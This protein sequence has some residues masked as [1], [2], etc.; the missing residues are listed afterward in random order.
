MGGLLGTWNFTLGP[1][2]ESGSW[3]SLAFENDFFA[4]KIGSREGHE[5]VYY[6]LQAPP[7]I[8]QSSGQQRWPHLNREMGTK[9][10][11]KPPGAVSFALK[12][13]SPDSTHP[14]L[15]PSGQCLLRS[16]SPEGRDSH[17]SFRQR[18]RSVQS[19]SCVRLFATPWTTAR[20][21]SPSITNSRS[22]L[23]PMSIQP[24]YH[25]SS[26]S[27][28]TFNLSQHQDL[29]KWVSTLH[30]VG[31]LLEFQLQHQSFQWTPRTDLL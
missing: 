16:L 24:S 31:N 25:L 23:K 9:E 27:P 11:R 14:C 1:S 29:S 22:L 5:K 18:P 17:H 20:Q 6:L 8:R 21:A 4:H 13:S 12:L 30:Q 15:P 19:L 2:R 26:P 10:Q 3:K 28:P 7:F